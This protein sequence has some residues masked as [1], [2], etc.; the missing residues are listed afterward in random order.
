MNDDPCVIPSLGASS[1]DTRIPPGCGTWTK[2]TLLARSCQALRL[3]NPDARGAAQIDRIANSMTKPIYIPAADRRCRRRQSRSTATPGTRSPRPYL[4]AIVHGF[5][6]IPLILPSLGEAID[7]DALLARV[8]GVLLH[9][10]PL[11]RPSRALRRP[12]DPKAE[13]HDP[14]RDAVT[15]PLVAATLRRGVPLFAICRGMQELNV[16]LGG[17]LVAEVQEQAGRS[18]HRAPDSDEQDVRF[19]I[20]QDIHIVPGGMLAGIAGDGYGPG[21]LASPPGDRPPRRRPRRRG[22]GAR[23]HHRSGARRATRRPLPSA[24][25]GTRNTGYEPTRLRRS[26]SPPSVLPCASA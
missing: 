7:F 4:A 23:R 6:G 5:G 24:C 21:E 14:R 9:R 26:C 13:P 12:A 8:D 1:T 16:A 2:R 18:D 19:A 10:Q 20:R 25:S 11:Q 3:A 17:T 15:L 22:D